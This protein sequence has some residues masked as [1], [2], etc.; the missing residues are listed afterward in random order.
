MTKPLQMTQRLLRRYGESI[1]REAERETNPDR[2]KHLEAQLTSFRLCLEE[3]E[4]VQEE[5]VK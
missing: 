1:R 2:K 5:S 3:V 4:K